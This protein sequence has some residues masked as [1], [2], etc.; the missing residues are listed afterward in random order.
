MA[1]FVLDGHTSRVTAVAF[2]P[3]GNSL[4][5]SSGSDVRIWR[6]DK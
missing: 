3:D 1:M 2:A 6:F 4:L 5:S